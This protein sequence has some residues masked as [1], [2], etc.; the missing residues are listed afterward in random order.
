MTKVIIEN[1]TQI[2]IDYGN[3]AEHIFSNTQS[4]TEMQTNYVFTE[5]IS[6]NGHYKYENDTFNYYSN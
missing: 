4:Y 1:S 6:L 3:W 5:P 2:V